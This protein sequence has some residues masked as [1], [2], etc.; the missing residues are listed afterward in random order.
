MTVLPPSSWP[1]P[2]PILLLC[3]AL[4]PVGLTPAT[5]HRGT[6]GLRPP[7]GQ[8]R[9][10]QKSR[11]RRRQTVYSLLSSCLGQRPWVSRAPAP[12]GQSCPVGPAPAERQRPPTSPGR[13]CTQAV[14]APPRPA[15]LRLPPPLI[16][17]CL[18]PKAA[19]S[20]RPTKPRG[21]A[22]AYPPLGL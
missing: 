4:C 6:R 17:P 10:R 9:P 5:A 18:P 14:T 20:Q 12:S 13:S 3:S 16:L 2:T 15:S 21:S 1:A 22:G 19:P 11:E 7:T 8:W